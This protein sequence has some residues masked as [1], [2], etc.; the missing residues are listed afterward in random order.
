MLVAFAGVIV[1]VAGGAAV[2]LV[3]GF[4]DGDLAMLEAVFMGTILAATSVSITV[5]ALKE[6]GHLKGRVATTI[7][8]AA[9][10]DDVIGIVL[11][12]VVIGFKSPDVQPASVCI[13]IVLFFV[14]AFV[15]GFASLFSLQ[16]ARQTLAA[17]QEEFR[18]SA[19]F[20]ALR[21]HIVQKNFSEL[22]TSQAHMLQVLSSVTSRIH[23]TSKE[24]WMS[25]RT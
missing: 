25:A 18:F 3:F 4:G 16:V 10:I 14:L 19:L 24:R 21:V 7:L 9:I 6:M 22:Q 8:S 11:L 17:S 5:Q 2:Y 15:L 13:N 23:S 1:S 20:S 12:T